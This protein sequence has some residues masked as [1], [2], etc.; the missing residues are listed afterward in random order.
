MLIKK[1]YQVELIFELLEVEVFLRQQNSLL[2]FR[3]GMLI[4]IMPEKTYIFE[5]ACKEEQMGIEFD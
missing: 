1:S 5:C 3:S 4:A 2:G